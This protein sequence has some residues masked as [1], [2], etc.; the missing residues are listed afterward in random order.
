MNKLSRGDQIQWTNVTTNNNNTNNNNTTTTNN[1]VYR[2]QSED[3]SQLGL[4]YSTNAT[5]SMP[6]V[7]FATLLERSTAHNF[8]FRL[9]VNVSALGA[10]CEQK[11]SSAASVGASASVGSSALAYIFRNFESN[12]HRLR[13]QEYSVG[14][15]TLEQIFNQFAATQDNPEVAA[16][17]NNNNN[18]TTNNNNSGK[19]HRG[20]SADFIAVEAEQEAFL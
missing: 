2:S 20:P 3:D 1:N 8:R 16:I 19:R 4:S 17:H 9:Q 10:I 6:A 14:Q 15:T 18:T 5:A 7:G 13:V 11:A 12:K